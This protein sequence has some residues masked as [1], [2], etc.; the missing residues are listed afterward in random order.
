[1]DVAVWSRFRESFPDIVA[2][3]LP[4]HH[5]ILQ[6]LTKGSMPMPSL[7]NVLFYGA[8]GFPLAYFAEHFVHQLLKITPHECKNK[9]HVVWNTKI[10]YA[11]TDYYFTIDLSHPDMPKDLGFFPEFIRSIIETS[12]MHVERH[13]FLLLNVDVLCSSKNHYAMRVLLESYSSNA[14]FI[15]TT[16]KIGGIEPPIRSRFMLVRVPLPTLEENEKVVKCLVASQ[17]TLTPTHTPTLTRLTSRNL[18]RNIAMVD[19]DSINHEKDLNYPPLQ[20]FMSQ[21][22]PPSI[23]DIR[24]MSYKLYQSHITIPLLAQDLIKLTHED[25]AKNLLCKA[26]DLDTLYTRSSRCRETIYLELLL[27]YA[28]Y[29]ITLSR[30]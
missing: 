5:A 30:R 22:Q 28:L 19:Y 14:L 7:S 26:A 24:Q 29:P 20:T 11:T 10:P 25:V 3:V 21:T 23:M 15:G 16:H 17:T 27:H 18:L 12:C 13:V 9:Q 8:N 2:T 1:M 4:F 6:N